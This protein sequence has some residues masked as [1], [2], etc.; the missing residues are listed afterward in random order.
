MSFISYL[1]VALVIT[2][3]TEFAV[4]LAFIRKEPIKLLLFSILI[5]SFTN[6]LINYFYNFKSNELYTLEIL[7]VLVAS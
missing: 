4:Y 2:I 7:V 5:N 6:P 3:I 1:A